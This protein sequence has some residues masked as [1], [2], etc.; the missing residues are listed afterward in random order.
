MT[1]FDSFCSQNNIYTKTRNKFARG[2]LRVKAEK[3]QGVIPMPWNFVQSWSSIIA[4]EQRTMFM[5]CSDKVAL[6]NVVGVQGSLASMFI[7]PIYIESLVISSLFRYEHIVRGCYSRIQLK[8][9]REALKNGRGEQEVDVDDQATL[10]D[11]QQQQP[12][13]VDDQDENVDVPMEM[14]ESPRKSKP[15]PRAIP[16]VANFKLNHHLVGRS[17]SAAQAAQQT[18]A[19]T[20]VS[21][22]GQKESNVS[23]AALEDGFNV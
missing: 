2:I 14:G 10:L 21:G 6:W 16:L 12:V 19:A 20:T 3:G 15:A 9:L 18:T 22:R 23:F 7:E 8:L 17:E 4:S 13:A 11:E 5:S 1:D